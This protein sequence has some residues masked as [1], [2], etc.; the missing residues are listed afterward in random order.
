MAA[1]LWGIKML[2]EFFLSDEGFTI[3]LV[4]IALLFILFFGNGMGF[5]PLMGFHD[6]P[7]HNLLVMLCWGMLAI[8]VLGFFAPII[9]TDSMIGALAIAA[10]AML[11][12]QQ[13]LNMGTATSIAIA[14]G[15]LLLASPAG[16]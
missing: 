5:E 10:L 15:V 7:L 4:V 16:F 6:I 14:L 2:E 1:R 12:A 9:F 3:L 11:A 13:F 8:I